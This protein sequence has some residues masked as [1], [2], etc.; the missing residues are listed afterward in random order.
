[1]VDG[2]RV[3]VS[4]LASELGGVLNIPSQ[5]DGVEIVGIGENAK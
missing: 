2:E 4:Y 3:F 1:M 5:I